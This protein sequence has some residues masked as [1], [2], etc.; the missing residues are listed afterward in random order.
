MTNLQLM[1]AIGIPT[2]M[3]LIGILLNRSDITALRSE[4]VQLRADITKDVT[5]F[6]A[7]IHKDMTAFRADIHKDMTTLRD[8]IHRDMVS[9]HERVA[10]AESKQQ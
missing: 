3:V 10:V 2:L 6:R 4:M 9:L 7:D 8:S 5:A 1:L